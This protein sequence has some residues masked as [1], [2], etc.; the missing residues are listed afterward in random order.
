MGTTGKRLFQYAMFYK[1]SILLALAFLLLAISVEL[2]GPVIAKR[3]IDQNILGIEKTWYEVSETSDKRVEYNGKYYKREDHLA[4]DEAKGAPVRVLQAGRSFYWYEGETVVDGKREVEGGTMT[5]TPKE[6][7]AA[8]YAVTRLSKDEVYRFYKPEIPGLLTLAVSYF[9]LLVLAAAFTYGQRMLLQTSANRIVQ[10]LREDVFAHSQRLSVQYFDNLPAG[11]IV[12]RITND[13]ET[14]RELYVAVLANF[15]SGAIYM[16]AILGAL[17]LLSPTLALIALPIVPILFAWIYVYRKFAERYNRIIRAKISDINAMINESINGMPIIQA[18]RR[19][20]QMMEEFD[21]HNKEFYTY[22][23]KMLSLNSITSHNLVNVIRNIIFITVIWLFWGDHLG[24]AITVGVLYAF[25]DYMN[26][27]FQPIVGIVN[28]LSNLETARISAERVFQLMDEPGI[29]VATGKIDRYKGEVSFKDVTF[30]YKDNEYVLKNISFEAKQGQTVA[31]V[32][33]TGSGKSSILNLLF[34]F[35]DI[36]KGSIT[37]DGIDIR[38]TPKQHI[39]QHMG[40][41][42][43]DPF[44][45]TGTIASNV[46]LDNPAISRETVVKALKDVGAYDMFQS[47]PGGIDEPVIE[48]GSTLSAGQRQL[49]SFARALAYDPAILILDEATASIDTETEAIIQ[50]ALDVLKKGRT[51]FVIAHRLSTIRQADQ[52]L[53]LDHGEIVERGNHEELM[54]QKGKYYGMYQLQLGGAASPVLSV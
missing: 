32:G 9:G 42:L 29:D 43:Q 11:K 31:L 23:K 52:I 19:Q 38:E 13:T 48:K 21:G 35:Y 30:A 47:L 3:M 15:F 10:K 26:R 7:A 20:K 36:E 44:L 41:V 4:A 18:F 53:V 40:I 54:E 2:I 34:R 50:A 28:Q 16:A 1:K 14:I 8:T 45:F 12:S 39:R 25:V 37:V 51:T 49:I 17:F 27:M 46:S 24:S 5:V 33:H 6:G 22:Q